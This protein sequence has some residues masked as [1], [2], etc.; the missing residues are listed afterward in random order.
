MRSLLIALCLLSLAQV[1]PG[2]S[3]R[4]SIIGTV[5]TR[6][7][8]TVD[9]VVIE[10]KSS[11]T[12]ALYRTESAEDGHYRLE[13][14]VGTYE[15]SATAPEFEKFVAEG[16]KVEKALEIRLDIVLKYSK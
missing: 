16:V 9:G 2:Q 10:A 14:P 8:R 13:L 15:I 6:L 3:E 5:S 1:I 7:T 4:G 11:E 12:A